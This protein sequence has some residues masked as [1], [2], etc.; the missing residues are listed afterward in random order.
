MAKILIIED[1]IEHYRFFH[2]QLSPKHE[3]YPK[4]ERAFR[5]LRSQLSKM[6]SVGNTTSVVKKAAK[7]IAEIIEN[8]LPDLYIMDYQLM[9]GED[10]CNGLKF[11][12]NFILKSRILYVTGIDS[13]KTI[14]KINAFSKDSKSA[15]IMNVLLKEDLTDEF[16]DAFKNDVDELLSKGMSNDQPLNVANL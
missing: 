14:N 3:V 6:Y 12:E 11:T 13:H 15:N 5:L 1:N 10:G 7:A 8:A 4:N 2:S 16:A 9:E